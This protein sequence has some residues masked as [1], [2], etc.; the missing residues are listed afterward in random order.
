M[1][2]SA[3]RC[4]RRSKKKTR[5]T[6]TLAELSSPVPANSP[7]AWRTGLPGHRMGEAG[8][9][10]WTPLGWR[11]VKERQAS[12]LTSCACLTRNH[13][14]SITASPP[15]PPS[16][17]THHQG[18]LKDALEVVKIV[19]PGGGRPRYTIRQL[20]EELPFDKVRV[21]GW[22]MMMMDDG[23]GGWGTGGGVGGVGGRRDPRLMLPVR[24]QRRLEVLHCVGSHPP[25]PPPR[26][27]VRVRSTTHHPKP[28][29]LHLPIHAH[30]H[31]IPRSHRPRP[32]STSPPSSRAC[33]SSSGPSRP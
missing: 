26:V 27:C 8:Q 3:W 31:T 1:G 22:W 32:S 19:P 6:N 30:P 18:L 9:A 5:E 21:D 13:H 33:S 15:R 14:P 4:P 16:S 23:A 29:Q 11:A 12:A 20:D 10:G 2:R 7:S 17:S 25:P 28:A 24:A